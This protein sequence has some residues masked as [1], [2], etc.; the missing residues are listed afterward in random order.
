MVVAAVQT[1]P[2]AIPA[3][4][5]TPGWKDLSLHSPRTSATER[6]ENT[7]AMKDVAKGSAPTV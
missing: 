6:A 4:T 5:T 2:I 1:A 3:R 7:K